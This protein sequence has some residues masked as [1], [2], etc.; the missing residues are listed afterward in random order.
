M[1]TSPLQTANG[2]S[3]LRTPEERFATLADFPYEPN[4]VEVDGLRMAYIDEGPRNGSVILCL[5]GEPSWSYLYRFMIPKFAA[6]GYRVVAPDLVGFGRSDKPTERSSYT[7]L[8]HVSWMTTF[9]RTLSIKNLTLFC[10]DWGGLIGLRIAGE[11]PEWFDRL[12]IANTALPDSPNMGEGF[13][14]WQAAS[15]AMPFMDCGALLKRAV[16][17]REL[18]EAEMD[19]Y[20]APFPDESYMAGAREFPLLVPTSPDDPALPANRAAWQVLETFSKPVLT[21]WAPDDIVLGKGQAAFVERILGAKGQPH[22][23]F[24]P[25][26]HFLQDDV[27]PALADAVIA[28]MSSLNTR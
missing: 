20:R 7:Y 12:V 28:W 5:H 16:Q 26:G 3:F 17:A 2:V 8:G 10:Q 4:Y 22:Q 6:A 19:S 11:H 15:Q 14:M 18:S 13:K 9:I 1:S 24:S 23:T 25:A 21:L 27:G